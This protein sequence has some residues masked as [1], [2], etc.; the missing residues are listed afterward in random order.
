MKPADEPRAALIARCLARGTIDEAEA[1][2][3]WKRLGIGLKRVEE[4]LVE[5]GLMKSG[6]VRL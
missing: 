1:V 2:K 3:L 5:A 6:K 4:M